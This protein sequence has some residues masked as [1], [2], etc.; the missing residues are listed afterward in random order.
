MKI[1]WKERVKADVE[2]E[3]TKR[4]E[5]KK[6]FYK[7]LYNKTKKYAFPPKDKIN[8]EKHFYFPKSVVTD[9][10]LSKRALAVYPIMCLKA[11][12][13]N[14]E[15]FQITQEEIATKSGMSINTVHKA[16]LELE[17]NVLLTREKQN[18]DKRHYYVYKVHFVRREMI[19]EYK[20]E[21]FTFNQSIVD[22]GT[23]ADLNLR[24]KALYLAFRVKAFYDI[25]ALFD[26]DEMFDG[27]FIDYYDLIR[28]NLDEYRHRKYD[29]CQTP[30][31]QLCKLAG[32]DSSNLT[33]VLEQLE[34]HGLIKKFDEC[35]EV[36]LK[37]KIRGT[38]KSR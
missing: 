12:F 31:S 1:N 19:E 9:L 23:W 17:S 16:L 21:Y 25:G 22:S 35:F 15:W 11:D 24:S 6:N 30:V 33:P 8:L 10:N 38:V 20:N 32:I 7:K 2:R 13:E 14:D 34:K 27:S 28:T 5:S 3:I 36:Y 18:S 26:D 29:M 37:P 4:Y